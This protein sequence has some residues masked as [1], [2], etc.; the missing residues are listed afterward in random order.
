MWADCIYVTHM[1]MTVQPGIALVSKIPKYV[2]CEVK[3]YYIIPD[4]T[5][6]VYE[7]CDHC[8]V[9]SR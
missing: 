2:M 5:H 3:P 1:H 4:S 8:S 7:G 9:Y 6:C